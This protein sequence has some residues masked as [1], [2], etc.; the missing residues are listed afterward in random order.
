MN[1]IPF[2]DIMLVLLAIVLTTSTLVEKRL[3]PISLPTSKSNKEIK[4][5]NLTITV[6][7]DGSI[8]WEESGIT[9]E[10]F[11]ERVKG[12]K[13]EDIVTINCDKDAEF[14][15]FVFILDTLKSNGLENIA[16][17]TKKDE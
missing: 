17:V 6:K 12:L 13:K 7:K 14:K 2:V 8:F 15:E 16:I 10:D 5:K 11:F 9:K 1:V 3:I 4:S